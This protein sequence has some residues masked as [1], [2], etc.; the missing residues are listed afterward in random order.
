MRDDGRAILVGQKT[1]GKAV[2]QRTVTLPNGGALHYTIARYLTPKGFDLNHKGLTPDIVVVTTPEGTIGSR[3]RACG[4]G[5]RGGPLMARGVPAEEVMV[6]IVGAGRGAI[7]RPAYAPGEDIRMSGSSLGGARVGDLARVVVRG[8]SAR[9]VEVFG[10]SR[11]PVNGHAR[12][13]VVAGQ[14]W[15][16]RARSTEVAEMV[17]GDP[18]ADPA[19]GT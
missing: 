16:H 3:A 8:R 15:A 2:V 17:E 5:R 7:A 6:E 4:P 11:A 1:F 19:G 10:R 9:V 13:P 14:G 18:L 12:V